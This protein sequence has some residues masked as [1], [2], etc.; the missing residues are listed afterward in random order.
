MLENLNRARKKT[1]EGDNVFFFPES[2]VELVKS[3]T[4]FVLKTKARKFTSKYMR[5]FDQVFERFVKTD[6]MIDFNIHIDTVCESSF[7]IRYGTSLTIE[8]KE[9]PMLSEDIKGC[10]SDSIKKDGTYIVNNR[11]GKMVIHDNPFFIEIFNE[12]DNLVLTLPGF[13]NCHPNNGGAGGYNSFK[14]FFPFGINDSTVTFTSRLTLNEK[15]Y[16]LGERFTGFDRRGQNIQFYH[17]DCAGCDSI[18]TY[19][20]VPFYVSTNNYGIFNNTSYPL[21]YDLGMQ[22]N[23]FANI[24]VEE[25]MMDIFIITGKNI[26]QVIKGYCDITGYAETLP[27]WSYGLWMSRNSYTTKDIALDVAKDV[28]Q[29]DIPCDVIH[30][31]TFWFEKDWVCDLKFDKERFSDPEKMFEQFKQMGFQV[32]IWQLPFVHP[33]I[34]NYREGV[35]KD[36]FVKTAEGGIYGFNWFGADYALIDFSNEE[37]VNWYLSQIET[38]LRMGAKAVKTDIAESYPMDG[39]YKNIEGKAMHNLFPL[40][41]NKAMY[42]KTKEVHG[43]ELVWSRSTYGAGQRY[44]VPWSGDARSDFNNLAG[45][46]RAGLSLG[47]SG[48]PFWSHD[49]GGFIGRPTPELYVRWAQL[50]LFSSHA[51]CHGG[52]NTNP[53]EPWAYGEEANEIFKKFDKLRYRLL[54]Y[55][56]S[57]EAECVSAGM[58]FIRPMVL[59]DQQDRNTHVIYDQYYFGH[60]I[61]VAP[62]LSEKHEREVYL[63][64]GIWYDFWTGKR[65]KNTG[66]IKVK[67]PLDTMPMFVRQGTIIPFGPDLQYVDQKPLDVLHLHVYGKVNC[68]LNYVNGKEKTLFRIKFEQGH[69]VL[70]KGG[71]SGKLMLKE[72]TND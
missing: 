18:R 37:A 43:D 30:I 22:N 49:I 53:R 54:P 38:V 24:F 21:D 62:V 55:I 32:S 56:F 50:G 10:K 3:G 17:Q 52:G 9:N 29:K 23:D 8:E 63:P 68:Q 48:Q 11:N 15:I 26:Q 67:A 31:D 40:L 4:H 47:M 16:G 64:E 13:D 65:M 27:R 58:P 39:V 35:E 46:L 70:D 59:M 6:E 19:K 71:Y 61:L 44:P 42:E 25:D 14:D 5:S 36:Y 66:W 45:A 20:N 28:R 2:I 51:R 41:Y 69:T 34:E 33:S 57:T 12:D 60:S 7:R 1:Y 72:M